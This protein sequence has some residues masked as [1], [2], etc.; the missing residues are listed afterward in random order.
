MSHIYIYFI[1]YIRNECL[2]N[3]SVKSVLLNQPHNIILKINNDSHYLSSRLYRMFRN[4]NNLK[5]LGL[6]V[7]KFNLFILFLNLIYIINTAISIV[8]NIIGS[9]YLFYKFNSVFK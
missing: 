7:Y 1:I 2:P 9:L 8:Y 3:S 6:L 5:Q 4:N